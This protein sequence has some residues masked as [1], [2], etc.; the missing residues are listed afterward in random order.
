MV[1]PTVELVVCNSAPA[2]DVTSTVVVGRADSQGRIDV[3]DLAHI[4]SFG[5]VYLVNRKNRPC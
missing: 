2:T 3:E 5:S 1:D 4:D